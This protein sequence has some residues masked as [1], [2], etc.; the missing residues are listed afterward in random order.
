MAQLKQVG[1][2]TP[3]KKGY[4]HKI[5]IQSPTGTLITHKIREM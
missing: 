3:R 4:D 2:P 5:I 1:A